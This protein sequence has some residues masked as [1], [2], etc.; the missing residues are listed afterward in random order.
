MSAAKTS[1]IKKCIMFI[2]PWHENTVNLSQ[3]QKSWSVFWDLV[4]KKGSSEVFLIRKILGYHIRLFRHQTDAIN[5]FL[6]R[7]TLHASFGTSTDHTACYNWEVD[8]CFHLIYFPCCF[9]GDTH[10]KQTEIIIQKLYYSQKYPLLS[11][12]IVLLG[13]YLVNY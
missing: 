9:N 8:L 2:C 11:K 13:S 12:S 1:I 10:I 7:H 4:A 5:V 6:L 3:V